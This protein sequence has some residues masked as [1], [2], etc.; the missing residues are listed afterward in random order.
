MTPENMLL[1]ALSAVTS[2]LVFVARILWRRS[3][4]CEQDRRALYDAMLQI[5]QELGKTQGALN[6]IQSC[7]IA[8]CPHRNVLIHTQTP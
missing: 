6:A 8:D 4:T 5:K 7:H 1:T 2:A 3:E